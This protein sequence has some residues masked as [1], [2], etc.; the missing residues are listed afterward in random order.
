MPLPLPS[1]AVQSALEVVW[2]CNQGSCKLMFMQCGCAYV[3]AGDAAHC[4]SFLA[5]CAQYAWRDKPHNVSVT[6]QSYWHVTCSCA[7]HSHHRYI[8]KGYSVWGCYGNTF[9]VGVLH[10][11]TW[12][13]LSI[14]GCVHV[15]PCHNIQIVTRRAVPHHT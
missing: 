5:Y 15:G 11:I 8:H 7:A 6:L 13:G 3:A 14:L 10:G 2:V 9:M 4:R 12:S 1:T